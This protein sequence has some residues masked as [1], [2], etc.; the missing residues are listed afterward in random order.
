M[1]DVV[2]SGTADP[3]LVGLAPDEHD[4]RLV[5]SGTPAKTRMLIA[6]L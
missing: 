3:V 5:A 4:T 2:A 6:H 1:A